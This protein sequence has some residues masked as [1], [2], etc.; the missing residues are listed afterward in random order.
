MTQFITDMF[1]KQGFDGLCY[2]SSVG[3]GKNVVVFDPNNFEWRPDSGNVFSISNVAYSFEQCGLFN[4]E[5]TYNKT[6]K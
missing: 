3:S 4:K 5:E 2:K 1:R 6:Y